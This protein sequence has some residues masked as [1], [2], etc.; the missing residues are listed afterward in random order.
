[1]KRLGGKTRRELFERWT[2]PT[3][4]SLPETRYELTHLARRH[5]STSTTT[6]S[7]TSTGTPLPTSWCDVELEARITATTVELFHRGNRVASHARSYVPYKHTTDASHMPE[8]HRRHSAG[9]DGVLAW[10][11]SV[12]PM[13]EA[14]VRRLI[15]ANPCPRAGVAFGA[16]AA[17]RWREVRT[18]A[19]GAGV[20]LGA[21]L[22]RAFLQARR[23][24]PRARA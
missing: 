23:A 3:S 4:S 2:A 15:D 13:T 19:H 12:G 5:A 21:A 16:W 6:S 9:V 7:S 18:R 20:R 1:M 14:M 11:A 24:H 17:A 10:G 22:Q 8:A